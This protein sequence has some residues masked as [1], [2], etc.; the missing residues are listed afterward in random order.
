MFSI[1]RRE[2]LWLIGAGAAGVAAGAGPVAV[3]G[4][5]SFFDG[6][7][8]NGW[9]KPPRKMRH[10]TG[11]SWVVEPGGV[12]AGEQDPPGS[13]N[14]GILL[15]DEQFGDFELELEMNPVGERTRRPLLSAGDGFQYVDYHNGQ[16]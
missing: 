7:T 10:G 14:G 4:F 13:S 3:N 9:H 6:T 11:G 12:L 5:K 1:Q 2:F 15:S 8:M 16:C